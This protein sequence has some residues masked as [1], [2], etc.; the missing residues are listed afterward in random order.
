[1]IHLCE[2]NAPVKCH[3]KTNPDMIFSAPYTIEEARGCIPDMCLCREGEKIR[4]PSSR[5]YLEPQADMLNRVLK[6][7]IKLVSQSI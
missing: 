6:K 1:M 7:K 4:S 3:C 5:V 2:C